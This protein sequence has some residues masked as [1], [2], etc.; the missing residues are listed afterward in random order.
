MSPS[1]WPIQ[2]DADDDEDGRD[3]PASAHRHLPSGILARW[4]R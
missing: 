2:T 1:P 4:T 3:D